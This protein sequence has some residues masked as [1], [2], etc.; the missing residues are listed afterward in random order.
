MTP[1]DQINNQEKTIL[2]L[3]AEIAN[4]DRDN[5]NLRRI[6]ESQKNAIEALRRQKDKFFAR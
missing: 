5:A 1:D 4:K 2:R 6:V 3:R